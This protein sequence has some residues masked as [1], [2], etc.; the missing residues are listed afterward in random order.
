MSLGCAREHSAKRAIGL[1]WVR[2]APALGSHVVGPG[3]LGFRLLLL[4]GRGA[5]RAARASLLVRAA[6][7]VRGLHARAR[8]RL[9]P[10]GRPGALHLGS[11]PLRARR[12]V[13]L[14]VGGGILPRGPGRGRRRRRRR[15][16]VARRD[17]T[18][19]RRSRRPRAAASRVIFG[20]SLDV[21]Q[22]SPASSRAG[23]G[24]SGPA[25]CVRA[26]SA[27]ARRRTSRRAPFRRRGAVR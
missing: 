13:H 25:R 1:R 23:R 6:H 26:A 20:P 21:L 22:I 24:R 11:A 12:D 4:V 27:S 2:E 18:L 17:L 3:G 7:D 19:G 14:D 16:P 15:E 9:V 8:V 10:V 5:A